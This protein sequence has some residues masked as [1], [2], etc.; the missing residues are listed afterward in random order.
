[1]DVNG[2]TILNTVIGAVVVAFV[3]SIEAV[4]RK[5]NGHEQRQAL[6]EQASESYKLQRDEDRLAWREHRAQISRRMD[7]L[8][9]LILKFKLDWND[10]R[11]GN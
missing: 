11:N 1:V 6:L 8:E 5:I 3:G 10:D 7:R 9:D 4:R 2:S